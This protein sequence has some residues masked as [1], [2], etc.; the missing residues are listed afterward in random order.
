MAFV[1]RRRIKKQ[2]Q[3]YEKA[4]LDASN[5]ATKTATPVLADTVNSTELDSSQTRTELV[6]S[7]GVERLYPVHELGSTSMIPSE[8]G[9]SRII[10]I[11]SYIS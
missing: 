8:L 2:G 11:R 5:S 6:V 3:G 4:E 9:D 7:G 1:R 10:N